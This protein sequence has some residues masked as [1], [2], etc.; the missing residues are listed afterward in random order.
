MAEN[1][2]EYQSEQ[3]IFDRWLGEACIL[4]ETF[5]PTKAK[6]LWNSYK[7]HCYENDIS[8]L[9]RNR[10]YERLGNIEGVYKQVYSDNKRGFRGIDLISPDEENEEIPLKSW[11]ATKRFSLE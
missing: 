4:H 2:S 7:A 11:K 6:R 5:V 9:G 10:F 1:K 8:R 3:D